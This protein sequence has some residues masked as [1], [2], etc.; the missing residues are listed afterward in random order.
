MN[1]YTVHIYREMRLVFERI[2]AETPEAAASIARDKPTGDADD[3]EDCDG[4]T[5]AALVDVV[6]DAEYSHSVTIDFEAERQRNAAPNLLTALKSLADQADED[7]PEEHRSRH[8]R[9]ALEQA[10]D[11][12]SEAETA[13]IT[14]APGEIDIHALLAK[15]RQIAVIWSIED[16]QEMRPDLTEDQCWEVLQATE[17]RQDAEIGINWE[18]L[19]CHADAIRGDAPDADE[20]EEA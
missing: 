13:G 8:F 6:G 10:R 5:L 7:C 12:I 2:E 9:D 14:P 16:V 17:R 20:A 11:T 3:I 4:E 15:R 18:V 19:S 1:I